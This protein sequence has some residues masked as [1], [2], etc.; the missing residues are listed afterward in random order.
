MLCQPKTE[1]KQARRFSAVRLFVVCTLMVC[2]GIIVLQV[3]EYALS[4]RRESVSISVSAGAGARVLHEEPET[5]WNINEAAEK[6]LQSVLGVGPELAR[7]IIALREE[8]GR[9]H[10]LEELKDVQGIGDKR[11]D[12]LKAYFFC[13]P[14]DHSLPAAANSPSF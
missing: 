14:P 3:V 6:D 2:A 9:F 1:N 10:F 7:R 5:R 4:F 8:R 11:F 12:M 13:P